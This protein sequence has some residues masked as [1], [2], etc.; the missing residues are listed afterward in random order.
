MPR[1]KSKKR[2]VAAA[3]AAAAGTL[4]LTLLALNLSS[5]EKKINHRISPLYAIGDAQFVR[6][7]GN[8]LGP[9]LVP[10]NTVEE[11]VNGD[12][13]FPSMLEAIRGARKT[14]TFETYIY[15]SGKIGEEFT[16]ALS[17]RARAGVK[18][19]LLIDWVGSG[20]IDGSHLEQMEKAGVEIERYHPLA[21][22]TL[23]RLNHRTHRK[24]LVVDGRVGFTGGVGIADQWLGDAQDSEHWRETHFRVEGPAVA[25]MQAAFLDNWLKTHAEVLHGEGYFPPL[26]PVGEVYAQV[27]K[28]SSREG[29]ESVRMM[30][31]LSIA[32]ARQSIL[33][34]ASYF[35]PD[36][37]SVQMLVEAR[38]RGVQIAIIVPGPIMDVEITRKASRARWGA[39]LSAGVEIFEY[40]PTM[41][42]CKVMI[43][44]GTWV[45]AGSTNFD[46][47][48]FRLNDEAN[49]NVLNPAFARALTETFQ[50]DLAQSR[51][52]TLAGWLGRPW[53]EK[54]LENAAALFRSQL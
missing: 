42:H 54:L 22:Y 27:F 47:R 16:E 8:L 53:K 15:W 37:L 10:G 13:I 45:S 29:S 46:N 26:T 49:L 40:Q 50:R 9:P 38:R 48:S 23:S 28:S 33:L 21:W 11:L 44:D 12:R 14:I 4:G 24:L 35:V 43:V 7:M 20:K 36:D 52:I 19:H 2:L 51:R 5:G 1:G 41:F 39:L 6:S 31:L 3:L 25:Q 18:V 32:A 17:E 30:Y 34:S